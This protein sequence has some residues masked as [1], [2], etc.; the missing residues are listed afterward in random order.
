MC[1]AAIGGGGGAAAAAAVP[2]TCVHVSH[3]VRSRRSFESNWLF[4]CNSYTKRFGCFSKALYFSR[5]F[6]E[7]ITLRQYVPILKITVTEA[8]D[9]YLCRCVCACLCSILVIFSEILQMLSKCSIIFFLVY[10]GYSVSL[11]DL[12][13]Q[14]IL[15][16]PTGNKSKVLNKG[17]INVR[18]KPVHI[19]HIDIISVSPGSASLLHPSRL[20]CGYCIVG[21]VFDLFT[22]CQ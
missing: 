12:S 21:F 1:G 14:F 2:S 4:S 13:K 15:N 11:L 17:I 8:I 18:L 20:F 6:S 9:L 22:I 5:C 3:L 19:K 10:F 16:F 7:N